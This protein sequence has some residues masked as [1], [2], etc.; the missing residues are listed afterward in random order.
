MG[1]SPDDIH[2]Y[3][4]A[5]ATASSGAV[6]DTPSP[7]VSVIVECPAQGGEQTQWSRISRSTFLNLSR[8]GQVGWKGLDCDGRTCCSVY[9]LLRILWSEMNRYVEQAYLCMALA[10]C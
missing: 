2:P 4:H 7:G 6:T 10:C 8:E 3:I 1:S 9:T 5:A